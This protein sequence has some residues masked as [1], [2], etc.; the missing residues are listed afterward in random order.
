MYPDSAE[1]GSTQA[2]KELDHARQEVKSIPGEGVLLTQS[3]NSGIVRDLQ[4]NLDLIS[5]S[6]LLKSSFTCCERDKFA[7]TSTR[8]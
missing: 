4:N 3:I 5:V 1:I 8:R 7:S 2:V 6:R